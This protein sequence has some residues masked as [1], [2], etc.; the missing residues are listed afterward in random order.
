MYKSKELK[1]FLNL[2]EKYELEVLKPA[3]EEAAKLF[4]TWENPKY[5]EKYVTGEGVATP[6]PIR[7]SLARIKQ[8]EKVVDK[9]FRKAS[10]FPKGLTYESILQMHDTLGVR[11]IVYFPSQLPLIDKELRDSGQFELLESSPPEAYMSLDFATRYGLTNLRQETKESGYSSVHYTIRLKNNGPSEGENPYFEIQVR[12]M[13]QELWSELEHV[14]AYK[15]ENRP[16]FSAKRRLQILSRQIS[17]IDEQFNLLYEE[18]L[19][20]QEMATYQDTDL[21]NFENLPK[22]LMEVGVRCA[23][24]DLNPIL[25]LLQS[26]G[27]DKIK[28]FLAIATPRRLE[29]IRNTYIS[30]LGRLPDVLE[31]HGALALLKDATDDKVEIERIQS[32][33]EYHQSNVLLMKK[34]PPL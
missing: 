12:T 32:Q 3:H 34:S 13:A 7:M 9:I 17:T 5:W 29:T 6:P 24:K 10:L 21:L 30:A 15:P 11:I 33:I 22:V 27:V 14:L 4:Q 31:L 16:H 23:L 19:H 1:Q 20:N 25:K 2:Y 18:L 8:P 26:H 28:D